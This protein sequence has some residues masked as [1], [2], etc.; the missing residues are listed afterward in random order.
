MAVQTE[1]FRAGPWADGM[2]ADVYAEGDPSIPVYSKRQTSL[3]EY[4][5]M[6]STAE[7]R[8]FTCDAD[9]QAAGHQA[10]ARRRAHVEPRVPVHERRPFRR[11]LG[12]VG[13]LDRPA[14]AG[15]A[16]EAVTQTHSR[17]VASSR[18][19]MPP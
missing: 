6:L 10:C 13:R 3:Q 1:P 7:Q 8:C 14:D 16:P 4:I 15:V 2:P 17:S 18:A 19:F 11:K 9:R 12:H 5:M